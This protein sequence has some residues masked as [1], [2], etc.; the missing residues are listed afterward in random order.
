MQGVSYS[1]FRA[2]CS[3]GTSPGI[4]GDTSRPR[5]FCTCMPANSTVSRCMIDRTSHI[6]CLKSQMSFRFSAAARRRNNKEY[7]NCV[8]PT[9]ASDRTLKR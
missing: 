9:H 8:L 7:G 5:S 6:S 3:W 4:L 1:S 2:C